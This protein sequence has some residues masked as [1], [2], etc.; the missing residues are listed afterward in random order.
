MWPNGVARG[1]PSYRAM[2]S[3]NR[4]GKRSGNTVGEEEGEEREEEGEG[5]RRPLGCP[6]R[7]SGALLG[8]VS[9]MGVW[10]LDNVFPE[11]D[12]RGFGEHMGQNELSEDA[13][14][15]SLVHLGVFS[16]QA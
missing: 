2:C 3:P 12:W 13:D 16:G 10:M 11:F 1:L 6:L 8:Q 15:V 14:L 9:G 4:F 7:H 5:R